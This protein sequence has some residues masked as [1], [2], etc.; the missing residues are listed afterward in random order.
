MSNQSETKCAP[1]HVA[2][3][4]DGNG[5]WATRRGLERIEGHFQG[6][7]ALK[8]FVEFAPDF[9]I[10]IVTAY[11]FSTENW[12]RPKEE[13]DALMQ[14][15]AEAAH[16]EAESLHEQGVKMIISGR[17]SE[18]PEHTRIALSHDMELTKDN[19]KLTLNLAINYGGR[20]EIADAAKAIAR[21]VE[22]GEIDPESVDEELFAAHLYAPGL[23]DPD[24]LIRTANEM[25]IS[26]FLLWEIAY[27]EI[28]V[29][30]KLWPDFDS[31]ELAKAIEVYQGRTR[32][33]GT[34]VEQ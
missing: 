20:A 14:L 17:L 27:S 23:P 1:K 4:M 8:R 3:I 34:V 31:D 11:G 15:I 26:N 13:T 22:N 9:G 19:T 33:F 7:R 24:L 12:H 21:R 32:K 10:E 2:V 18:L 30:E 25:R 16:R 5:R 28:Y 6:Y 29:T